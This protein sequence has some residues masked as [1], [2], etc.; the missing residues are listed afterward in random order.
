MIYNVMLVSSVGKVL[1]FCAYT[2]ESALPDFSQHQPQDL[3][4]HARG[5]QLSQSL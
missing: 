4:V 1:W 3:A 5:G 2:Q